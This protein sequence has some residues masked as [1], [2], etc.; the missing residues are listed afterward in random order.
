MANVERYPRFHAMLT[1]IAALHDRKG[2]DYEGNGRPY[3]NLRAGESIGIPAWKY[4]LLRLR[5]KV[6]RVESYAQGVELANEP[7]VDAFQD[8]ATLSL[9]ALVLWEEA[10]R[11]KMA[12]KVLAESIYSM[13]MPPLP[14]KSNLKA[15]LE[16]DAHPV[17]RSCQIEDCPVCRSLRESIS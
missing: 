17:V 2:H 16:A 3:E 15:L 9:I 1:E 13:S 14:T 5:E 10:E 8:I 12:D 7:L 11:E 4:A 6:K